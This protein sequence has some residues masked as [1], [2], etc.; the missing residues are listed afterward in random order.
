MKKGNILVFIGPPG[1]GKGTISG[2]CT[3]NLGW[4]QLSTGDL[5]RKHIK[6]QTK[7][8]KQI[9]FFIK[10]GKLVTDSIII[11]MVN[12][13]LKQQLA[14]EKSIILDGYPRTIIQAEALDSLFKEKFA[15]VDLHV[16]RFMVPDEVVIERLFERYICQNE[17]CQAVYSMIEGS[18][19]KP[20]KDFIC[21]ICSSPLKRRS[22]DTKESII[23]RLKI[24]YEHE[25]NLL[26]FYKDKVEEIVELDA[27]KPVEDVI[28]D[29]K[30]LI[31]IEDS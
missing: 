31:G 25:N 14:S 12:E 11:E 19:L 6:E 20:K 17:K 21:D 5:C 30:Q 28:I 29:L 15:D 13:W 2:Y 1:S 7:I 18:G 10:S 22:D 27:K 23:E 9:D 4:E 16:L 26:N 24:Y 8:G 3:K